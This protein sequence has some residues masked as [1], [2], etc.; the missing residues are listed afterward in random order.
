MP[1]SADLTDEELL[2]SV[3]SGDTSSL[4]VRVAPL[5]R[6]LFRFVYRILPDRTMRRDLSE[7]S[8]ACSR[9]LTASRRALAFPPGCT[10]S[11]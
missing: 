4:G 9:R 3:R 1:R 10:R 5:E 6:P 7:T 8:C 11:R 2:A